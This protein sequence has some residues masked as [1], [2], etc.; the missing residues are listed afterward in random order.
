MGVNVLWE[1]QLEYH[2]CH[3][4]WL[5]VSKLL[6]VIPSYALSR[7]SLSISLDDVHSTSSVKYGQELPGYNNYENFL[8]ELET[9]CMN[10]PGIKVFR[11]SATRAVSAWLRMLMEQQLAKE[12]I[13]LIDY[14]HGTASIVPL[15]AL[16][17]FMT[18]MHD[19]SFLDEANDISPL[20]ISDASTN[21]DTVEAL[22]K[23]V[24]HFC[25]QYDLLNL[26]D[27]YLDIHKL[28]MDNNSLSFLLDAVVSTYYR[29][30]SQFCSLVLGDTH[31]R[32]HINICPPKSCSCSESC[33]GL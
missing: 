16:S 21:P 31:S 25:A 5:E 26:L 4:D 15:L 1:S 8:D 20:V 13:F 10:V 3:H 19:S 27:I 9:V 11:F 18:D 14:W 17:G 32:H 22:H 2:V 7:G 23:V 30:I 28:A 24:I 29:F 33:S 12:F 6:E